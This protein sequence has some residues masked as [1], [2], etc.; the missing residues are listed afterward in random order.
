MIGA[1]NAADLPRRHAMPTK[2]PMYEA[3][4]NWTGF[5]VGINGGAGWGHSNWERSAPV[6]TPGGLVG[7]TVGYNYQMGQT[8]FGLEGD[9]DWADLRGSGTC[10]VCSCETRNDWLAT[11]RG[12]LGYS[13]G[14]VM[15]FVTGGGAFGDIKSSAPASAA[16]PPPGP[17]GRSAAAPKS[18]SPVRGAPR[19]NIFTSI[20]ARQA[21]VS[22]HA[23]HDRRELHQQHRACRR[24]LSLL[25]E[26]Q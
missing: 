4:Y 22:R 25:I 16:R 24:Q 13:F 11:A 10:G 18:P 23:G 21:A 12:R 1:A 14:R 5:Y 19:S 9:I 2:A 26:R 7:G 20:S 15:P 8:V 17:A 6:S 3:P